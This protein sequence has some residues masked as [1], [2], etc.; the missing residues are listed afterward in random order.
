LTTIQAV[1]GEDFIT[2]PRYARLRTVSISEN[3]S[4]LSGTWLPD[5]C[6]STRN[7]ACD[8]VTSRIENPCHYLEHFL[9]E[10]LDNNRSH[11]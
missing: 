11:I 8:P 10:N 4:R 3:G 7:L 5:D 1:A 6:R 2:T 9:L